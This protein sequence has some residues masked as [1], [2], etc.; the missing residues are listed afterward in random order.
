MESS[1]CVDTNTGVE[2]TR[3]ACAGIET[4][5]EQVIEALGLEEVE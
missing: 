4:G 2:C 5:T 3:E 1:L